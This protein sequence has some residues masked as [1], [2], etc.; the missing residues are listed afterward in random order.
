MITQKCRKFFAV[1]FIVVQIC[2]VSSQSTVDDFI[3]TTNLPNEDKLLKEPEQKENSLSII[4]SEIQK[5]QSN[6]ANIELKLK[7]NDEII[8]RQNAELENKLR[9]LKMQV[10]EVN[11][12]N[13]Q[14]IDYENQNTAL[15]A[16]INIKNE[17]IS[18]LEK[19]INENYNERMETEKE[20]N[21]KISD[22]TNRLD[23]CQ[24][25]LEEKSELSER[26]YNCETKNNDVSY[27]LTDT[28]EYLEYTKSKLRECKTTNGKNY[29][30]TENEETPKPLAES[31]PSFCLNLTAG[32]HKIQIPKGRVSDVVCDGD[33]WMII[34]RRINGNVDF[35]RY[36]QE[37]EDGFGDLNDEFWFGLHKLHLVTSSAPHRL[38]IL[39]DGQGA[40]SYNF[41]IGGAGE[42]YKLYKIRNYTD[43][44][45]KYLF[46]NN[47]EEKFTTYDRNNGPGYD[48]RNCANYGY[49]GWWHSNYCGLNP[50]SQYDDLNRL[51]DSDR[52]GIHQITMMIR[53]S[54]NGY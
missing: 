54:T 11:K 29:T 32:I 23:E 21:S 41:R 10:K 9:L 46:F 12:A 39:I 48:D 13:E 44:A 47:D 42:M 22:L 30:E 3:S 38:R 18:K 17:E 37:Y 15:N 16:T 2:T 19:Q 31:L 26:L 50:N 25:E 51:V 45:D 8:A 6:T 27:K 33:G 14:L 40:S 53:P 20:H 4:L 5:I 35:N 1:F 7:K 28:E 52:Y 34:Q 36:W 43:D 49:G 24:R